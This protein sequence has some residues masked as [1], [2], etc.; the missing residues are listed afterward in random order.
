MRESEEGGGRGGGERSVQAFFT[1]YSSLHRGKNFEDNC[2]KSDACMDDI[3]PGVIID[4]V[5]GIDL[6]DI[7][8]FKS[9]LDFMIQENSQEMKRKAQVIKISK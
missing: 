4:G 2:R 8:G 6:Q 5:L 1:T 7:A 9:Q 3:L